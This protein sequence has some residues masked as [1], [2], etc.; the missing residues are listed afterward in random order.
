MLPPVV[1]RV[2]DS[3]SPQMAAT[4]PRGPWGPTLRDTGT[5]A[6]DSLRPPTRASMQLVDMPAAPEDAVP[7][8]LHYSRVS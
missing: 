2:C 4:S 6:G 3:P 1:P 8:A 5:K 7:A